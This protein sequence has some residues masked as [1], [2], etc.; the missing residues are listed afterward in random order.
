MDT[1]VS[2]DENFAGLRHKSVMLCDAKTLLGA[3]VP[4][5][6]HQTRPTQNKRS[7][8]GIGKTDWGSYHLLEGLGCKRVIVIFVLVGLLRLGA[9]L[10]I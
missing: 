8:Q 6:R 9:S 4:A 2:V 10:L 7:G 1:Y 3:P 5:N